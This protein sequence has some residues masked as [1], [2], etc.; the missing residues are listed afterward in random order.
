MGGPTSSLTSWMSPECMAGWCRGSEVESFRERF[1]VE[2]RS[3]RRSAMFVFAVRW[4]QMSF[5]LFRLRS[6]PNRRPARNTL[7]VVFTSL[8]SIHI[9]HPMGVRFTLFFRVS[10][11]NEVSHSSPLLF[12]TC[13]PSEI[14]S[15]S[16]IIRH[17]AF[18]LCV[19]FAGVF[20]TSIFAGAFA[21][22]IGFDVGVTNLWDSWN[23]GV[24]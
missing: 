23:R 7:S 14:V 16:L 9:I 13:S 5:A 24:R 17:G 15:V 21:F 1:G 18:S 22:G 12:T 10:P 2:A 20:V 11:L 3:A 4:E 19:R 8:I 6:H